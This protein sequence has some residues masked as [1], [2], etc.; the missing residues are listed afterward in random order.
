MLP[1]RPSRELN[2]LEIGTSTYNTISH[3]VFRLPDG[4]WSACSQSNWDTLSEKFGWCETAGS[5]KDGEGPQLGMAV[6]VV[7]WVLEHLP[8]GKGKLLKVSIIT[9]EGSGN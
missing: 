1:P 6:D 8:E 7:P 2:Y 5:P 4:T 9:S 3:A